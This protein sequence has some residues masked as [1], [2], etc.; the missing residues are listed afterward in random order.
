MIEITVNNFNDDDDDDDDDERSYSQGWNVCSQLGQCESYTRLSARQELMAFALT[1]CPPANIQNLLAASSSLQTQVCFLLQILYQ[2]VNYKMDSTQTPASGDDPDQA[3]G[4]G[5]QGGGGGGGG[6]S[7]V[8]QP[9]ALLQR[10]TARTIEVLT[11]TTVN[12]KAVLNT[13]SDSQWWKD[14]VSYLRPL[15][16]QESDLQRTGSAN[17]N[18]ELE[19]QG[20]CSFYEELFEDPYVNPEDFAE[21]LLRTGKLAETRSEG[22]QLF[23]ATEV[24][25]QLASDAFSRDMTLALAY[26]LA[27]PQGGSCFKN[28]PSLASLGPAPSPNPVRPLQRADPKELIRLVTEHVSEREGLDW[29]DE[30]LEALIGQLQ[31]YSERLTDF[32]QAQVLRRLGRG[33]DVQR[34]SNDSHYKKETILGLAET[35]DESVYGISRSLAQRYSIPLWEV[36]MTHLEFLF[37]DSGLSTKEIETRSGSLGLFQ[38]LKTEPQAFYTHMSK[39]VYPGIAGVDLQRLLYYYTLL[40]SCSGSDCL[41]SSSMTPDTHVKLLK[42]LKAV[43]NGLDYKKLTDE[44]SDPLKALEP[45]LSSQNVLSISKLASR[46]PQKGGGALTSSAIHATWLP[47]LFWYGDAHILKQT[48]QSDQDFLNAYDTCAKYLDRLM[49]ADVIHFLDSVTFSLEATNQVRT[50]ITRRALKTLKI[51]SEKGRKRGG[52]VDQAFDFGHALAHLQHSLNHLET[53]GQPFPL[54]LRNS[55]EERL[56]DYSRAFDLSRSEEVK[57]HQLAVTM[58]L[59]GQPLDQIEKLLAAAVGTGSLSVHGVVQ[60]AVER[61]ISALS[62]D[63]AILMDYTDPLKVLEGVVKAVQDD[64]QCGGHAVSSEDLLAWLR[65]FCGDDSK[66]VRVRIEVLQILEHS[67]SL[68]EQDIRLL[69]LFRSQAVLKACWPSRELVR[70][71]TLRAFDVGHH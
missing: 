63:E 59:D 24:L 50:E 71:V 69:V 6:G 18:A 29:G 68:S 26:L 32:T 41:P 52:D 43:A 13:I 34:F 14:P 36:Y 46:I 58:A 66:P 28:P 45:V 57:V 12:T 53:L 61:I 40:E 65:P 35:L 60:D 44:E 38:T 11:N 55:Q 8:S 33:V 1:H 9:S 31:L 67:F 30:E 7:G 47:K 62:G 17:Q 5:G 56:Q 51:I 48:P 23:P 37:T 16:G 39:Y 25:L 20:C 15:Q 4:G 42:K 3:A 19:R 64:V 49:P 27:L 54:S 70:G 21:V 10:T 2:A 22:Q